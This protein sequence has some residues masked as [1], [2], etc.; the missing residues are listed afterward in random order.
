MQKVVI[1]GSREITN[2]EFIRKEMNNLWREIGPFELVSGMA[3]GVDRVSRDLAVAAGITVHEMPADW[4]RYGKSA[5]YR[6][7]EEMAI[8]ADYG[9]ILWDG[10]SKGTKH[11]IDLMRKHHKPTDLV[12]VEKGDWK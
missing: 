9:L 11:M 6:R 10:E 1:A 8:L 3:R 4:N 5:G 2:R 12:I 7:N